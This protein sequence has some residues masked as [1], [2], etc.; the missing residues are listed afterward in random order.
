MLKLLNKNVV[1]GI[2]AILTG[3]TV[4]F[5]YVIYSNLDTPQNLVASSQ[6]Q[7]NVVNQCAEKAREFNFETV[8]ANTNSKK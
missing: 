7:A 2:S 1:Y 6:V 4:F 8:K 5:I 3:L